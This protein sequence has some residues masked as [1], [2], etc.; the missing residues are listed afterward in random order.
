MTRRQAIGILGALSLPI[1]RLTGQGGAV[2]AIFAAVDRVTA[3]SKPDLGNLHPVMEWIRREQRPSQSFLDDQWTSLEEWKQQGRALF[4]ERLGFDPAPDGVRSAI[5]GRV[6]R[7]GFAV[8]TIRI[9]VASAYEIPVRLLIPQGRKGRLPAVVALH[10]HSGRF[11]WGHEKVLSDPNESPAVTTFRNGVYG[12]PYAEEL[13]RRGYVVIIIDAFYFGARRLQIDALD[14]AV[15][16]SEVRKEFAEATEARAGTDEWLKATNRVC[17]HYEH[18]T[19][20]TLI[21]AGATWPGLLAWDDRRTIDY[22]VNR[23]EVDPERIGCVG[24]S[25]GG[26]RAAHL[27]GSDH[28]IKA[29]A[30]TGFMTQ[31]GEQLRNHLRHHTWMG[32]VPG[33]YASL[34]LPDVAA[35]NAPRPLLVQQC[36][37][38]GLFPM[39]GMQGAVDQLGKIYGKAGASER[40]RGTFYDVKHS[41]LPNMQDE[42]FEWFDRW[43]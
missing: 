26:M 38:D 39:A 30:I 15:V 36:R 4:H 20:K 40:F 23:P 5:L 33:L 42:A 21:A 25:L 10:C 18:L 37:R 13:A 12:R 16:P 8:E 27:I 32:F 28:R 31:F 19:A 34:D 1:D 24:L 3:G 41:F 2:P 22:L 6:E 17:R 11:V 29:A 14:P 7:D 9:H 43:L 35:L